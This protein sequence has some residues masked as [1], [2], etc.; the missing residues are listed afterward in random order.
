MSSIRC[1]A[2]SVAP[3]ARA[4]ARR[5]VLSGKARSIH[6]VWFSQNRSDAL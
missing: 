6:S 5:K 2:A 3:Q 1:R 4:M